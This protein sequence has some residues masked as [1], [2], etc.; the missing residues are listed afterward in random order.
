MTGL[1]GLPAHLGREL[2]GPAELSHVIRDHA[3]TERRPV[4]APERAAVTA[5]AGPLPDRRIAPSPSGPSILDCT[6]M[7]HLLSL[8][9]MSQTTELGILNING[10]EPSVSDKLEIHRRV[11][12]QHHFQTRHRIILGDA[13]HMAAV[14]DESVHLVLTSPP[15]FDLIEYPDGAGQLGHVHDYERFLQELDT[16][17]KECLRVLIP[18]GRLCIVVG[19]VCRARRRFGKHEV[20]PLHADILVRCRQI[21]YEG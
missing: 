14:Q 3:R 20:I 8:D 17:W 1:P 10:R 16:V 21:G 13:R 11:L 6:P 18:G 7:L 19:D 15:Y 4:G 12:G 5:R 9:R 2:G